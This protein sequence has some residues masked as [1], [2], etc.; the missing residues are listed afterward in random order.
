[1]DV[2]ITM[3]QKMN[4]RLNRL[5]LECDRELL[6]QVILVILPTYVQTTHRRTKL[7]VSSIVYKNYQLAMN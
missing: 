5:R 3:K 2:V 1:M 6:I 4:V 7:R